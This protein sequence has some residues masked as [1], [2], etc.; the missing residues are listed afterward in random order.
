MYHHLTDAHVVVQRYCIAFQPKHFNTCLLPNLHGYEVLR[1]FL[2]I[3]IN[4]TRS[5]LPQSIETILSSWIFTHTHT[6]KRPFHFYT[7][8]DAVQH[9]CQWFPPTLSDYLPPILLR[10]IHMFTPIKAKETHNKNTFFSL[11]L[12]LTCRNCFC[13]H[14]EAA[15]MSCKHDTDVQ[16]PPKSLWITFL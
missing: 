12:N 13:Q 8:G 9:H 11:F 5:M 2:A 7:V 14:L 15:E 6:H 1:P 3:L 4:T 16:T 10:E